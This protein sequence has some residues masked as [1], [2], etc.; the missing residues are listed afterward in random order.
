MTKKIL[1]PSVIAVFL[2]GTL[3]YRVSSDPSLANSTE[4]SAIGVHEEDHLSGSRG[5]RH[6]DLQVG[7]MIRDI[8]AMGYYLNAEGDRRK[9]EATDVIWN[10]AADAFE[11]KIKGYATIW[12]GTN[13]EKPMHYMADHRMPSFNEQPGAIYIR[14]KILVWNG[15]MRDV[16]FDELWSSVFFELYNIR[17]AE[18]FISVYDEAISGKVT[19]D[20]WIERN[21]RLEH[22]AFQSLS[23]FYFQ[24]WEP[25][26]KSKGLIPDPVP[27]GVTI[28]AYEEW[29][30][31][32]PDGEDNPYQFWQDY[33]DESLLPYLQE[34]AN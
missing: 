3:T 24:T 1:V 29:I 25:W 19:R 26:A 20:Q 4:H 32:Y 10:S 22:S 5:L 28:P 30:A 11:N 8:P 15:G 34:R 9:I 27:W 18:R 14:P 13:V 23:K 33:Y 6:G 21:T 2:V 7:K 31:S 16:T 12:G 17:N